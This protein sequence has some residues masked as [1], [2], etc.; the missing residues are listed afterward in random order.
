VTP[1]VE[2]RELKYQYEDGTEAL[3]GVDFRLDAG[4]SVAV[5]GANGSGKSTFALHLNGLL[6][7]EGSVKICGIEVSQDTAAAARRKVGMVFQDSDTQLFMPTVL[8]DV[9]FGLLNQGVPPDEAKERAK[10]ALER[11]GIS[12]AAAKA[13]YHLSAGE[14]KKVAIAGILALDPEVMVLD[15]PTTFLDPPGQRALADLL[16]N[17]PQAKILIT[18]DTPFALA[19]CTRAVF[20]SDGRIAAEDTVRNIADRFG[21]EFPAS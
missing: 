8:E 21:W 7:G 13:P 20:F 1:L 9:A 2:V 12:R 5:F 16:R 4:E 14:K 19:T 11:T 6:H 15:E 18:H 10:I 17:L 3:R